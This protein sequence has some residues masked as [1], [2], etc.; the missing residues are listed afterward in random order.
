M[1]EYKWGWAYLLFSWTLVPTFLGF[2]DALGMPAKVSKY[3]FQKAIGIASE[4]SAIKKTIEISQP[5]KDVVYKLVSDFD[6]R[7]HYFDNQ[8][9]TLKTYELTE[10]ENKAFSRVNRQSFDRIS[11][12]GALETLGRASDNAIVNQLLNVISESTNFLTINPNALLCPTCF[13]SGSETI[14]TKSL[15]GLKQTY[16]CVACIGHGFTIPSVLSKS[17]AG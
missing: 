16:I 4:V 5:A 9:D 11:S 12:N 13:G 6:F 2:I 15:L 1:G 7:Q 17:K 14:S 3:N 8:A 10:V